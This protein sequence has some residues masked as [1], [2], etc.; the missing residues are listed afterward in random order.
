MERQLYASDA[1]KIA[2]ASRL[3]SERVGADK[4]A[5]SI[6]FAGGTPAPL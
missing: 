2:Q 4:S 6:G 3:C 1:D 5:A